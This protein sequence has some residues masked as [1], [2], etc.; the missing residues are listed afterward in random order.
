MYDEMRVWRTEAADH[1]Y[2]EVAVIEG[3]VVDVHE[4]V[5]IAEFWDCCF[6]F[7]FEAVETI[8]TLYDPLPCR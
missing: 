3:C 7:E 2:Y 5:M 6:V 1:G 8:A 4:N